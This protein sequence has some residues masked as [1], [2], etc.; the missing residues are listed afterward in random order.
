M[1]LPH[2]FI[3]L[4][5]AYNSPIDTF[6]NIIGV[7]V[8]LMAP[9]QA[10]SGQHLMTFKLLDPHLRDSAL[11]KRGL[12]ARWFCKEA[13]HLPKVRQVG[14]VVLIRNIKMTSWSQQPL[15]LSNYQTE[16]TVFPAA[17][18]PSPNFEI[19][20]QGRQRVETLGIPQHLKK[21][22]LQ[23]QTYVIQL[24][25]DM[26]DTLQSWTIKP[27]FDDAP[28][29]PPINVPTAPTAMRKRPGEEPTA[30]PEPKRS[31]L[32]PKYKLIHDLRY[33]MWADLLVQV[34][35]KFANNFGSCE[36]YVTDYTENKE[37]FYYDTPEE[38]KKYKDDRDGD[39]YDYLTSGHGK[40]RAWPGPY[41]WLVLK[42]NVKDP[43]AQYANREVEE[44]D[45]V[46]LRNVKTNA[47]NRLEGDMWPDYL[48][49]EKLQIAKVKELQVPEVQEL[50]ERKEKYWTKRRRK[51]PGEGGEEAQPEKKKL[52]KSERKKLKKE[53]KEKVQLRKQG[54]KGAGAV[55]DNEAQS[56]ALTGSKKADINP[57]IRCIHDSVPVS[58]I[59]DVLDPTNAMHK[60]TTPAG[61]EY[62]LPFINV[63]YRARV[64]VVDF[65]P[66]RLEDFVHQGQPARREDDGEDEAVM[67]WESS[68]R[69]EWGFS[70]Q[71]EDASRTKESDGDASNRL[72]VNVR[73]Q[74]AQYLFGNDVG[75]PEDLRDDAHLLAQVREKL[76]ILWGN[77]EEARVSGEEEV[78]NR[79]FECCIAEYGVQVDE[80]GSGTGGEEGSFGF[81][82]MYKMFGVTIL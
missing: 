41:G 32:G 54:V 49:P 25:H 66:K 16:V 78:S 81:K 43:H 82:R 48:N 65:E 80:K 63:K 75:D 70:L 9:T 23:E 35:K 79:P 36:L 37:M 15:A 27:G 62:V 55:V 56:D 59:R 50:L 22:T 33:P 73:H 29:R 61:R 11:S 77:L 71:L 42:M 76:C 46:L 52:T 31:R 74:D 8:D 14:D 20:Y 51:F 60:N 69:W 38:E 64:R 34:V 4:D 21:L 58:S 57:H 53:E 24:K 17:S 26:R 28:T 18:I 3:D 44:G 67:D 68:A 6:V 13:G 10:S 39:P 5:K 40:K 12:P 30:P 1:A 7:V 2:P 19:A 72:W 47:K 45:F